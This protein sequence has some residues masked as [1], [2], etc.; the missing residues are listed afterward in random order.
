ML[1]GQNAS[2]YLESLIGRIKKSYQ[3]DNTDKMRCYQIE[4]SSNKVRIFFDA[5]TIKKCSFKFDYSILVNIIGI[6][7]MKKLTDYSRQ[8]IVLQYINFVEFI[9][10][11]L[12]VKSLWKS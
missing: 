2:K 8:L 5:K 11:I 3:V 1:N 4:N 6:S 12:K 10:V 7:D 9:N